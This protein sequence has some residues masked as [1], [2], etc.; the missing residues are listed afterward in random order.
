M[1]RIEKLTATSSSLPCKEG[2]GE[3]SYDRQVKTELGSLRIGEGKALIHRYDDSDIAA[4]I[5]SA[6]FIPSF[7]FSAI[8]I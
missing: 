3:V 2:R 8:R 6:T 1:G 5:C 4:V 7:C